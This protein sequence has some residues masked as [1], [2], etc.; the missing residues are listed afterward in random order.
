MSFPNTANSKEFITILVEPHHCHF[1]K[2]ILRIGGAG[3]FHFFLIGHFENENQ[4]C[5]SYE[6]PFNSVLW[7]IAL[8]S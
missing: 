3:K 7:M 5:C 8:E 1:R 4:F 6:V 2:I